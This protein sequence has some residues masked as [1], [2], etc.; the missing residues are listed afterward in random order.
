MYEK[1]D[2]GEP[3]PK[4]VLS[5]KKGLAG[6]EFKNAWYTRAHSVCLIPKQ[7]FFEIEGKTSPTQT[8]IILTCLL[9]VVSE[10]QFFI[11]DNV[12]V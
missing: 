1:I 5:P 2:M 10:K 3:V 4:G 7:P 8:L 12:T 9:L 6:V 11:V